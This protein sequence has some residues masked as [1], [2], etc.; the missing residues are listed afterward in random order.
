MALVTKATVAHVRQP[1]SRGPRAPRRRDP[2]CPGPWPAR[3]GPPGRSTT[4]LRDWPRPT[5]EPPS[6]ARARGWRWPAASACCRSTA[7][8]PGTP[9]SAAER[10]GEWA[11][12]RQAI[13]ELVD[14]A[15]GRISR[16]TGSPRARDYHTAWTG[17]PDVARAERLHASALRES[18]YQMEL[19]ATRLARSMRVR[20]RP[21]GRSAPRWSEPFFGMPKAEARCRDFVMVGR[22]ALHAG[23]LDVARHLLELVADKFGGRHRSRPDE[24][25]SGDRGARG[26]DRTIRSP[27]TAPR[28]P[29]TA[30]PAVGSMSR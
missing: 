29:A 15:P 12:A 22:F 18:D 6:S 16:P 28:S 1:P 5:H 27:S 8:T 19:N 3:A 2:R 4:S 7:T 30:K 9:R 17:D 21:T 20:R 24:P 25:P 11:W 13:G 23:Q 26:S 14:G 10:L